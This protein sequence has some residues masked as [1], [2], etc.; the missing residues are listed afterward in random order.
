MIRATVLW[1][2]LTTAAFAVE[3]DE[4]LDNPDL[5]ARAR[6]LSQDIRCL[7]CRNESIDESNAQLAKDLRMLVRERLVAGDTDGE[8]MDFLVSRY[9]EYVL[10]TPRADG[11]NLLLWWAAPVL[12]LGGLGIALIYVRGRGKPDAAELT[13]AEKARVAELMDD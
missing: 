6:T 9:G 3:P 4:V 12:F 10:L 8:V 11:V 7:V 13:E 2:A 1:L 5:E